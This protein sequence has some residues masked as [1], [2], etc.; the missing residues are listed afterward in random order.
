MSFL[1]SIF[2]GDAPDYSG[3]NAAAVASAELGRDSFEWFKSEYER[4]A[5]ERAAAA[6]IG[7]HQ[8]LAALGPQHA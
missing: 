8:H 2:G 3:V 1:S 5:P 7:G 6:E 4:T